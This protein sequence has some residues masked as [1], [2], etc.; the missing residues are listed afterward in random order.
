MTAILSEHT[1]PTPPGPLV[2]Y[3]ASH[4][5]TSEFCRYVFAVLALLMVC[6]M[7]CYTIVASRFTYREPREDE[8]AADSLD[9]RN[10][11][12]SIGSL[13]S[14]SMSQGIRFSASG[15]PLDRVLAGVRRGSSLRDSRMSS[16][17]SDT[18]E[19]LL[20]RTHV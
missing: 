20:H 8:D 11:I 6:N 1:R 16:T 13:R 14:T 5:I 15:G 3:G 7:L 19:S 18:G 10:S 2:L 17:I 12:D 9:G 4:G